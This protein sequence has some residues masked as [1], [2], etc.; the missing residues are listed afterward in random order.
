MV[1][2][3]DVF[4]LAQ[5]RAEEVVADAERD[6]ARLRSEAEEYVEAKLANFEHTLTKTADRMVL[7]RS[8]I[9]KLAPE[10]LEDLKVETDQYVTEKLTEFENMLV[11]AVQVL[12]K[13]RAQLTGGHVHGLADDTDVGAISL[14]EHLDR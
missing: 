13:G 14:P 7:G 11:E 6:A 4:K 2:D 10:E 9:A 3:T 8:Q 1:S 5:L 12:R